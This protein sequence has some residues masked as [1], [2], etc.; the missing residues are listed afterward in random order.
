MQVAT[1]KTTHL[2]S[3]EIFDD[4]RIIMYFKFPSKYLS[5]KIEHWP[6]FVKVKEKWSFTFL[7]H[8]IEY[9][10]PILGNSSFARRLF[11]M[12]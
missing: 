11:M 8:S 6:M 12:T 4:C 1:T 5:K 9:H 10:T 2:R 3:G 7:T